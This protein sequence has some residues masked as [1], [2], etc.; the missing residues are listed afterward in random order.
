MFN[1]WSIKSRGSSVS[2]G[3]DI[4]EIA[5]SGD[6]GGDLSVILDV[7]AKDEVIEADIDSP[8]PLK[9]IDDPY[10]DAAEICDELRD[11][12]VSALDALSSAM[13]MEASADYPDL[14]DVDDATPKSFEAGERDISGDGLVEVQ[15]PTSEVPSEKNLPESSPTLMVKSGIVPDTN[16]DTVSAIE[17]RIRQLK[18]FGSF[19]SFF[20]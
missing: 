1:W 7:R 12:T 5:D 4:V 9:V 18:Y 2:L 14:D 20:L 13:A 3:A 6:E 16:V 17:E 15:A 19:F 11:Y 8:V 10:T